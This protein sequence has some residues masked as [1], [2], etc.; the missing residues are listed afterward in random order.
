[1]NSMKNSCPMLLLIKCILILFAFVPGWRPGGYHNPPQSSAL[2]PGFSC[3]YLHEF[4]NIDL[5]AKLKTKRFQKSE[6]VKSVWISD[7]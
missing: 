6:K 3:M 2:S 1:M 5:G 4:T 7:I